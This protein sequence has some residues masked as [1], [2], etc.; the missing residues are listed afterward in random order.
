LK[1]WPLR[2]VLI[3]AFV[4]LVVIGLKAGDIADIFFKGSIL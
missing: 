1:G 4:A 3:A 2:L